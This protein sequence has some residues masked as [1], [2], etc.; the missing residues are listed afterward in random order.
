VLV[1]NVAF[2]C[3][4]FNTRFDDTRN[5][6]MKLQFIDTVADFVESVGGEGY[7]F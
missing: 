3:C 1:R 2:I 4:F 7:K 6:T 5:G